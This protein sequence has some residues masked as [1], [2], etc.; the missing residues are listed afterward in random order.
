[1]GAVESWREEGG[2]CGQSIN[3]MY[4]FM[5]VCMKFSK[6]KYTF[7]IARV[8]QTVSKV[9]FRFCIVPVQLGPTVFHVLPSPK[10]FPLWIQIV[11]IACLFPPGPRNT[12]FFSILAVR[13]LH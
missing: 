7:K 6:I 3:C 2:V 1:V 13:D 10:L 5:H 9:Y 4:A 11:I 8:K 12:W